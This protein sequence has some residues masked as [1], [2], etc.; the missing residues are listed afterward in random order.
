MIMVT[1]ISG[2]NYQGWEVE[3]NGEIQGITKPMKYQ[4][5]SMEAF[6]SKV[7]RSFYPLEIKYGILT[8]KQFSNLG[9]VAGIGY[10]C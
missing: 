3:K 2:L 7:Y 4:K 5:V 8:L 9:N 1:E 6:S 10:D